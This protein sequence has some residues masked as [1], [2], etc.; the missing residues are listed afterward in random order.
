MNN[1]IESGR[2]TLLQYS[3]KSQNKYFEAIDKRFLYY[4]YE[5]IFCNQ[6]YIGVFAGSKECPRKNWF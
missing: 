3:W 6:T 2:P 4:R 1:K 5:Y